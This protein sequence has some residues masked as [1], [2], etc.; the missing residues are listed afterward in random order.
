[1]SRSIMNSPEVSIKP[2]PVE[3]IKHAL[4]PA[5]PLASLLA[6]TDDSA[7]PV[8]R[9][10]GAAGQQWNSIVNRYSASNGSSSMQP[11]MESNQMYI[12]GNE[13]TKEFTSPMKKAWGPRGEGTSA[14]GWSRRSP[15]KKGVPSSVNS[16]IPGFPKTISAIKLPSDML[17]RSKQRPAST[18][19]QNSF[20]GKLKRAAA[21]DEPQTPLESEP[22]TPVDAPS[23]QIFAGLTFMLFGGAACDA[24]R[25]ALER[26]GGRILAN[27]VPD[28]FIARLVEYV[29][30]IIFFTTTFTY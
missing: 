1:M 4:P 2:L 14:P 26:E 20:L 5:V 13:S 25:G 24:V 8:K 9:K 22:P 29:S 23:R 30:L 17:E 19:L 7:L 6:N 27:G 16:N 3:D 28:Y 12:D 10:K 11:S 18:L 21:F 15:V